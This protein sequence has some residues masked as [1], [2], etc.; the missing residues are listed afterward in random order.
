MD[1]NKLMKQAQQM[2]KQI[3]EANN[4]INNTEFEGSASNGLIKVVLTGDYKIK[5]VDINEFIINK[6][7][8]DM[9]QDL[10]MIAVNEAVEKIDKN[11]NEK[12]G[13]LTQG[14]KY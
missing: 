5:T 4:Q 2:Q 11:K 12:L 7:D 3:E 6:E 13:S 14:L 9:I 10:F 8:K 1:L